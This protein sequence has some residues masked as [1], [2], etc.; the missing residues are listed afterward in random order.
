[1]NKQLYFKIIFL[2]FF[3]SLMLGCTSNEKSE[4]ETE[5]SSIDSLT[6]ANPAETDS[7]LST[8]LIRE[9]VKYYNNSADSNGYLTLEESVNTELPL[10]SE[11]DSILDLVFHPKPDNSD[12]VPFLSAEIDKNNFLFGDL[13]NDGKNDVIKSVDE[14]C[15]GA[16]FWQTLFT[17]EAKNDKYELTSVIRASELV[18]CPEGSLGEN[19]YISEIKNGLLYGT[20]QCYAK[21]D[22][23]CCPSI[24]KETKVAYKF[25]KLVRID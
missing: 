15:G 12:G 14:N 4:Y 22:A 10:T 5:Q 7:V 6:V 2:S 11:N 17:F 16:A 23:H 21:D 19:F 13:N 25:N 18:S 8:F 3:G 9:I 20:S 1:M 24:E